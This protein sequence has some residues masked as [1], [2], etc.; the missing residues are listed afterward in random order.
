MRSLVAFLFYIASL[1][2][3][4]VDLEIAVSSTELGG[5]NEELIRSIISCT[6]KTPKSKISIHRLPSLRG[7]QEFLN[8]STDGYYPTTFNPRK[9]QDGLFP[10]YIDEVLMV[11]LKNI[12][13]KNISLGL[14]Q[15]DNT[16]YLKRLKNYHLTF[17]VLNSNTLLRGLIDRRA[18]AII[19]KRSDIPPSFS[20][21]GYDLTSLEFV[22]SGIELNSRF[23]KKVKM[24]R[25]EVSHNYTECLQKINFN[26]KY[27][28]KVVLADKLL[29]DVANIQRA[30]NLKRRS[31]PSIKERDNI[32][33]SQNQDEEFIQK[34][35]QSKES[36]ELRDVLSGM[37]FVTEA[38]VFNYQGA[39]LGGLARTSDFDQSDEKKYRLVKYQNTFS[40]KNITDI[41][42][43]PS[44]GVFQIGIM[45]RL[46]DNKGRFAGGVYIGANINKI[47]T[48]YN[49]N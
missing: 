35:L 3:F 23:Y 5:V 7:K 13:S 28:K 17:S 4:S 37:D 31:I 41:Y 38:F 12:T 18:E 45:I 9:K 32:W 39:I 42:F 43:D 1:S 26:L 49:I 8:K 48:H 33:K 24:S 22:E 25:K 36:R 40:Q 21:E 47:L 30:L 6:T 44:A 19:I 34:V 14:V 46:E 15:G 29:T 11:S 16:H 27:E 2:S 10:L 20:L